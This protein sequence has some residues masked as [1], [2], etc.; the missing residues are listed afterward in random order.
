MPQ[1]IHRTKSLRHSPKRIA[2]TKA[3]PSMTC[4]AVQ[5]CQSCQKIQQLTEENLA[6]RKENNDLKRALMRHE[7]PHTPSSMRMYPTRNGDHKKSTK[8]FP[9]RPKG[10]KGTTR[11]KPKAPDIIKEPQKKHTCNHCGAALAEPV[12][13]VHRIVEEIPNRQTRQ[14]IDFLEFEYKCKCCNTSL[15]ARHPDCPPDG[16][17]GKNALIQTTLMKFGQRLP[18][19]KVS[20]QMESQF[21]LPMTAASAFDITR[22]VSQY[23]RPRY[24]AIL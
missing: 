21:A 15:S 20:T 19:E 7:N 2:H 18:F 14:V 6:L 16:I 23:L 11:Q 12:H 9:G 10:H 5:N 24:F 4:I 17:F 22:R 13:V 1:R 3:E 8:R